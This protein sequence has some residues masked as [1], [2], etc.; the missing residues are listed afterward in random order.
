MEI[1]SA[2]LSEITIYSKYAKYVPELRRRETWEELV[3][4]NMLMHIA[5]H[6]NLADEIGEV[7][8]LVFDKKVLPSMRSLQFAGAPIELNPTRIFNCFARQTKFVTSEGIKSFE[9][10]NHGDKIKVL[11][12]T[13]AWQNAT[14]KQYGTQNLNKI[15]FK[16][17]NSLERNIYATSNHRWILKNG[18]ST[19]NLKINDNVLSAPNVFDK[20]V[21]EESSPKERS[22]VREIGQQETN[23]DPRNKDTK[24][25]SISTSLTSSTNMAWKVVDIQFSHEAEV[26]CLEVENDNSFVLDCGISTGNCSYLPI[27]SWEAFHEVMFLLLGGTGVGYSVQKKHIAKLPEIKKPNNKKKRFL[28][29]DSIEG[30]ADTIKELMHSYFFGTAEVLFDYRG[31]RPK[32]SAI[33]TAGGK[34]PGP[35]PLKKAV[36]SVKRILDAKA[37]NSKLTSLEVHD[38]VCYISDAVLAGGIRR[39]ALIAGFSLNDEAMLNAKA[40]EWWK[41]NGQRARANNTAIMLRHRVKKED[42]EKLW[43][44]V[45]DSGSGEPGIYFSNNSEMFSNPSLRKG[46]KVLT[47][48]GIFPI[49]EL[50]DKEF[51][52]KNLHGIKSKAKCFLS[53]KN[54]ELYKVTLQNRFEYFC[55]PEHKWA[56]KLNNSWTKK[57]TAELKVGDILPTLRQ[58]SLFDG[59][60]GD[61][62]DGFLIGWLYGDGWICSR[63]DNG[64]HQYGLCV[65]KEDE[66]NGIF[67]YL[68]NVLK[69]KIGEG[70]TFTDRGSTW[71]CNFQRKSAHEYFSKFGVDKKEFGLPEKIWNECSEEFRKGFIDALISSDGSVD[72]TTKKKIL[73][74][75]SRE[76]LVKDLQELLGFYG[77]TTFIHHN[78]QKGNKFPNGIIYDKEYHSYVL[79]FSKRTSL[80]HFNNHFSIKHEKKRM[81]LCAM[82]K[83]VNIVPNL[84]GEM[85]IISVEKTNLKED[86]WDIVVYDDTHCFQISQVITGNCNEIS[87]KPMQFC[88]LTSINVSDVTTQEEFNKRARAAAFIGT[89]QASYTD[90]HYLRDIW[91]ETTEKEALLGV[92]MTGIATGGVLKLDMKEAAECV[93]QENAR[94]AKIV[95][96][97]PAA[98]CTAVKP[99]GTLSLV[100]GS[101]SG[102]HAWHS[103]YYIRRMRFNKIEPVAEYLMKEIPE[104]IEEDQFNPNQIVLSIPVKAPD[105]AITRNETAIEMLERVKKVSLDWVK[106]GHRRGDNTHNVSAT[107]SIKED[108]WATVG[109]W[110]WDNKDCYNGLSVLPA[111]NGSYVQAPFQDCDELTYSRLLQHAKKIDLTKVVEV[112]DLTEL[113]ENLACSSGKCDIG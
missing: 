95:G 12:H 30:W 47:A 108:E 13:G 45:R 63:K 61:F 41:D 92:S 18:E 38:I 46:T 112:E 23:F 28:I 68:K 42:F 79:S 110:M 83:D 69:E 81:R 96:I 105:G 1:S 111:D 8:Q 5:K 35:E 89:L 17:G 101:S 54:K 55:T 107:V 98:R 93:K 20:F 94:I 44:K 26:W 37:P 60:L 50:Q 19:T 51:Y 74:S 7:Y 102:I 4:R 100:V 77:I 15:S 11:S 40:G 58:S 34:A 3:L 9:D 71:E 91:K 87:L 99:E 64:A 6:P 86:V 75:S 52:V 62:K 85:K 14:V 27:D 57:D 76:K 103:Q 72:V 32:G 70:I 56:V 25:Y 16:R 29:P 48:N 39:S 43:E 88:N 36:E 104:L 65:S 113:K 2:L 97:N 109:Q 90:F 80:I 49:E 66:Q 82:V 84:N 53:G 67:A 73:I 21:Y 106:T 10:Y 24:A 33:K 59:N 31:I 78:I 22:S